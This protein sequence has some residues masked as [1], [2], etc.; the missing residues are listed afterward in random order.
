MI[1]FEIDPAQSVL[2]IRPSGALE[3]SDFT[4]LTRAV[5]AYLGDSG[6]LA[7]VIIEAPSFPGWDSLGALMA[8]V[9]FVREHHKRVRKVAVVTDSEIGT[10]AERLA[11]HFVAAKVRHFPAGDLAAARAWITSA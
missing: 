2:V 6:D 8:H 9:K 4:S 7:G 5:D 3:E 10:L 11:S 1:A